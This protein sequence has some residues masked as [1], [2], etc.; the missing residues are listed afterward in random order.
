MREA[1]LLV[2]VDGVPQAAAAGVLGISHVALR[3]RLTRARLHL[4]R[5]LQ[6]VATTTAGPTDPTPL[7]P[8]TLVTAPVPGGTHGL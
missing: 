6:G 3:A 8:T 7:D 1:F 5:R 2:A 4:R